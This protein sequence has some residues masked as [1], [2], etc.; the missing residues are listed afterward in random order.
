[1]SP[2]ETYEARDN[3]M[4]FA[5]FSGDPFQ[6]ITGRG[7]RK[8][9]VAGLSGHAAAAHERRRSSAVAPDAVIAAAN[10]HSGYDGDDRLAPIQSRADDEITPTTSSASGYATTNQAPQISS[11]IIP[12][13]APTTAT[14]TSTTT[15]S[16]SNTDFQDSTGHNVGATGH[17]TFYDEATRDFDSVAPDRRI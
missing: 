17:T 2:A 14:T 5:D 7:Q 1:M 8:S 16:S 13:G 12:Q 15:T 4:A 11:T 9:S 6:E 3:K 10:H